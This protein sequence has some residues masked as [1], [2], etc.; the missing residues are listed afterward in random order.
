MKLAVISDIHSNYLVLQKILLDCKNR[1]V[2]KYI[3]LGDYI[4]DGDDSDKII[5]LVS[6]LD[7]YFING[8]R[9][10]S[11]LEY[12]NGLRKDWDIFAQYKSMK[13]AHDNLSKES[14]SFIESLD[15]YKIVD[16][17]NKKLCLSH[18]TPYSSR[19]IVEK[20]SYEMFDRLI[21]DIPSD[22]YLFGHLHSS[23][24]TYYK[25]KTFINPGSAGIPLEELPYK[26]GI[27]TIENDRVNYDSINIEYP[28]KEIEDYYLSSGYY[29]YAKQWCLLVL[30]AIN[31]G[32]NHQEDFIN[33][34][35]KL[36]KTRNIDTNDHIPNELFY[37]TFEIY[38]SKYLSKGLREK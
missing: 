24:I 7:G 16:I 12:H 14:I 28:Y 17:E 9:E 2:D 35:Q 22:I 38:K 25:N 3:F 23:Y 6:S 20:D 21:S 1:K 19:T 26:Y 5:K 18:G 29:K 30:D 10:E 32:K 27:L 8:N 15:I 34:T 13:Y 31:T 33:M 36:G 37:E 11:I 4:S